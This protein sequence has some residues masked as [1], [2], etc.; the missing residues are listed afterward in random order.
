MNLPFVP[1]CGCWI[2]PSQLLN[3]LMP[4]V[5]SPFVALKGKLSWKYFLIFPGGEKA[6]GFYPIIVGNMLFFFRGLKP[7][8]VPPWTKRLSEE[9]GFSCL[10][11]ATSSCRAPCTMRPR[12]CSGARRRSAVGRLPPCVSQCSWI[13]ICDSH[14]LSS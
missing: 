5:I 4:Y 2:L 8:E 3:F 10:R 14:P 6:N 12:R 11:S 7:M 1:L 13:G 9:Q